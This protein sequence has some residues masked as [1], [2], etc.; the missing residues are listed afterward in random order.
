MLELANGGCVSHLVPVLRALDNYPGAVLYRRELWSEMRTTA[1]TFR[2]GARDTL[3]ETAWFVRDRSRRVGRRPENRVV[4][5]VLL[6]KGLEYDHT[7]L[8]TLDGK[9]TAKEFYVAISRGTRSVTVH[10]DSGVVRFPK[11]VN[12]VELL[13]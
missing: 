8:L 2:S 1:L 10:S 7:N 9:T 6:V 3:E 11:P 12:Q 4:S 13:G 5:R